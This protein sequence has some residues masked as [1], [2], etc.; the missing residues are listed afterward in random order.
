M[1]LDQTHYDVAIFSTGLTQSI[2]SAALA[3]A[4]LSVIHID[5]NDYYADQWASLTLSELL[6][7][8]HSATGPSSRGDHLTTH[9]DHVELSFPAYSFDGVVCVHAVR[10]D[11]AWHPEAEPSEIDGL[12]EPRAELSDPFVA[13][14]RSVSGEGWRFR[15]G[16]MSL[17]P[18]QFNDTALR[19]WKEGVGQYTVE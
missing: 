9:L 16:R 8:A 19:R 13:W 14:E 5:K 17:A 10:D 18:V 12:P 15:V 1:S 4:G 11:Q 7:W 6:K 3:S 2:L